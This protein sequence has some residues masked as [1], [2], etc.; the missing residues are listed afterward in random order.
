MNDYLTLEDSLAIHPNSKV[1]DWNAVFAFGKHRGETVDQVLLA[2]P[3]YLNWLEEE[4]VIKFSKK[5]IGYVHDALDAVEWDF[6]NSPLAEEIDL[7]REFA[8]K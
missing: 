5:I 1:D 4:S 2:D 8:W 6:A 3:S 7:L